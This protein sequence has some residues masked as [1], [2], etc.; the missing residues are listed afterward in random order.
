MASGLY[1]KLP[2]KRDF[3]VAGVPRE[4]LRLWEP[5]MQ[6]GVSASQLSL[7][8]AWQGRFFSAPIWRFWLGRRLLGV[9]AVGAFMPSVDGIGR[10]FPLTLFCVAEPPARLPP[11]IENPQ[12]AWFEAAEALLLSALDEPSYETTL[13]GLSDLPEPAAA[14]ATEADPGL[15]PVGRGVVGAPL[16]PEG[17]FG[18]LLATLSGA[19]Q[20]RR[21]EGASLWWTIGGATAS[22]GAFLAEGMPEAD[23]FS[24]FLDPPFQARP[25]PAGPAPEDDAL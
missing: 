2:A 3:V 22:P 1:G 7:G 24:A 13:Q 9:E 8:A 21:L 4:V 18:S 14:V 5:W 19:S 23:A 20:R 10:T 6:G 16:G 25:A 11:P 15:V 12:E 17:S